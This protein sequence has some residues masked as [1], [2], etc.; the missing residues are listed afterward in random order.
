VKKRGIDFAV[1]DLEVGDR[2]DP[3]AYDMA[4]IGGAQDREQR[5]VADDLRETKAGPLAEAVEDGLPVLAVCGGYQLMGRHYREANGTELPG[6]GIL[7]LW[8]V[9]PGAD[10]KRFIGNVVAEWE[11]TTLVGFENHGGRTHLGPN[12]TPWRSRAFGSNGDD[13][14]RAR[15][16]ATSSERTPR[17]AAQ[18]TCAGRSPGPSPSGSAAGPFRWRRWIR[19]NRWHAEAV[20]WQPSAYH[21]VRG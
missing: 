7:D 21:L 13:G 16:T 1:D 20:R 8:T 5:R 9:H 18:R 3:A 19:W 15:A 6:L 11:G 10:A 17:L 2:L 4:F 14:W 12:A